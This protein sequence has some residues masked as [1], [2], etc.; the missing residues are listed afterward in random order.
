MPAPPSPA[1]A[2]APL[3]RPLADGRLE[4]AVCPR[5]CRLRPGQRGYCRVRGHTGAGVHLLAYGRASGLCCDPIE[6][7]PLNHFL[8]GTGVLSFG[9]AGCN[10]GCRFC[11]N[12]DLSHCADPEPLLGAAPPAALARAAVAHGCRAVAFTYNE[13]VVAHEAC[14]DTAQA[15]HEL[16]LATVA[17]TGGYQR[18]AAREAFYRHLD[19]A[20]VDLK[21]F[22]DTFYRRRC[23]GRLQPVLE[24]LA[25]LRRET[26]VWLEITTLL[27][28]GEN[29]GPAELDA[30][31]AWIAGNLGPEVPLHFT[32]FHPAGQMLDCPSTPAATLRA[33]RDLARRNG[34]RHV[35]VGNVAAGAAG[36]TW[37]HRCGQ[38]L[39]GR[40]GYR[41]SAW[42]LAPG[43]RC[44]RCGEPCAGVFEERPGSWDGRRLPVR[45]ES[46]GC[47]DTPP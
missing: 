14:V 32:A 37:C 4:C 33:A 5:A 44:G 36:H 13:P 28:P 2:Q 31:S 7:K 11:Q 19:A 27:I 42:N 1:C 24:T 35:Y 23:G 12:W 22:S 39:I 43:G 29:D 47:A 9:T 38:L 25:Y 10:L 15:C 8:P 46:T 3:W 16:G 30:L 17:V 20:S 40:E 41:L 26:R 18:A 21:A 34:L 6:K 45:L